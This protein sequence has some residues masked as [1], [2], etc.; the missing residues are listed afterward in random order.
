MLFSLV[1]SILISSLAQ[2]QSAFPTPEPEFRPI[3]SC[4]SAEQNSENE[5]IRIYTRD[6]HWHIQYELNNEVY[7]T[8]LNILSFEELMGTEGN[9]LVFFEFLPDGRQLFSVIDGRDFGVVSGRMLN[10]R[11]L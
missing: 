1:A 5:I 6:L 11:E 9:Y 10:C 7:L 8:K 2:S 3:I 4:Q